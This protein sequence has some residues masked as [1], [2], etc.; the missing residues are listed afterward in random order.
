MR[1]LRWLLGLRIQ[2]ARG[3]RLQEAMVTQAERNALA[4]EARARRL[5]A[6]LNLTAS[7]EDAHA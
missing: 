4:W 5:Q 2:T 7:R 1:A 6:E 3:R